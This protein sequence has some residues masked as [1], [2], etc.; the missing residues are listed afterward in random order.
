MSEAAASSSSIVEDAGYIASAP[1]Q[2]PDGPCGAAEE[3]GRASGLSRSVSK[4]L[5]RG[6][7][8]TGGDEHVYAWTCRP[9]G[10]PG[11]GVVMLAPLADERKSS[12]RPM[13]EIARALAAVG[14]ASVRIDYRGTGD[15]GGDS[16][17]VSLES[18]TAD[19]VAAAGWLR[20][21][22]GCREVALVGLRLGAAVAV[23]AAEDARAHALV[24]VE[25]VVKGAS[26]MREIRRQQSVR[27][28]LTRG[29]GRPAPDADGP[30]DL[31]GMALDRA[32]VESLEAL[33]LASPAPEILSNKGP[34]SLVLQLGARKAA[35]AEV[36]LL[37]EALGGRAELDV[38]VAEPFWL[39]TDYVD[40]APAAARIVAFLAGKGEPGGNC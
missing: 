40:P 6:A 23:L 30:F 5:L 17:N 38:L 33:D 39:Q 28:L 4:S 3:S 21:E 14:L 27:R 16:R 24:L 19:V 15:S 8:R 34:R 13:V 25:P 31:D 29:A 10:E 20:D 2:R 32:F 11:T 36:K 12:L 7:P 18:M 35:S 9:K 26:Y 22:L 1:K 37:A